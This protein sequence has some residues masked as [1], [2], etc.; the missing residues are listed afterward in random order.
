MFLK[1]KMQWASLR[2]PKIYFATD[3]QFAARGVLDHPGNARFEL[4]IVKGVQE[5]ISR[6]HKRDDQKKNSSQDPFP[7]HLNLSF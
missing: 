7:T 4:V 3:G 6:R 2:L 5:H 1:L